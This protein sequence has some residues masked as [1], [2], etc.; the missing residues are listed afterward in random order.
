MELIP[1]TSLVEKYGLK[2]RQSIYLRMNALG[3][4]PENGMLTP[5]DVELMDKLDTHIRNKGT[6]NSFL[7]QLE[8]VNKSNDPT[9]ELIDQIVSKIVYLIQERTPQLPPSPENSVLEGLKDLDLIAEKQWAIPTSV[10][11]EL[12][13]VNP[14]GTTFVRG[15]FTFQ[16]SGKIGREA[17][18]VVTKIPLEGGNKKH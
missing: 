2:S 5:E 18:W 17:A 15:S 6:I 12:I 16:K 13:G 4:T 7:V 8:A 9:L 3:I 10:V 11:R 1:V 14:S